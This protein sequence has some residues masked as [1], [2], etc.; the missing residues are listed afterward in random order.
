MLKL[1][2]LAGL[3]VAGAIISAPAL[4]AD[5]YLTGATTRPAPRLRIVS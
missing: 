4:A 1:S 5:P 3:L 2:R